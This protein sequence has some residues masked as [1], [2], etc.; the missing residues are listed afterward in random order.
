MITWGKIHI[1]N[2]P[3]RQDKIY[4]C[5]DCG[6]VLGP[7]SEDWKRYALVNLAPLS[8]AQPTELAIETDRFSLREFYC[9]NCG[10][11]FE[12]Q[13]LATGEPDVVTFKIDSWQQW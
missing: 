12:V 2:A 1:E 10:T 13:M 9:P 7:T 3:D 4:R 8:K 11:M 6:H 5:V